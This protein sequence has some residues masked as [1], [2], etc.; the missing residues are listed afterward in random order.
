MS[1][2]RWNKRVPSNLCQAFEW[3]KDYAL[4][5]HNLSV[6]QIAEG[7]GIANHWVLY[8]WI[9]GANMPAVKIPAYER[10]CG[11]TFVSRWLAASGGRMVVQIPTGK[12]PSAAE[13]LTLQ[14][15]CS[16]AI[17]ALIAFYNGKTEAPETMARLRRAMEGLAHHHRNV[18]QHRTPELPLDIP[19]DDS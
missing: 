8:K 14:G 5:V 4:D 6:E 11:V 10:V 2:R 18:E 3:C 17:S 16:D 13:V 15:E 1:R 9:A 12:T 19:E 7:M